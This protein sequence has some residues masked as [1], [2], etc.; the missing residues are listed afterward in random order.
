[1]AKKENKDKTL[2][3]RV[4]SD[5]YDALQSEADK[6][7]LSLSAYMRLRLK[8]NVKLTQYMELLESVDDPNAD[9]DTPA[10]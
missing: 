4:S 10:S 9:I 8:G 3:I 1:M 7:G 2:Q 6:Y 5:Q